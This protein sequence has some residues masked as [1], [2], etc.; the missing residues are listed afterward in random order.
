MTEKPR[1]T[2]SPLAEVEAE[3]LEEGR[4]WTRRRLE[5]KLQRLA[6]RQGAI[7]PPQPAA[8]ETLDRSAGDHHD[9]GWQGHD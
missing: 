2:I 6:D 5:E 1:R 3:T 4:A 9:R 8:P 7:S